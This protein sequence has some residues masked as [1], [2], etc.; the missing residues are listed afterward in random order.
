M[1][2]KNFTAS[3]ENCLMHC[4]RGDDDDVVVVV[5]LLFRIPGRRRMAWL[6]ALFLCFSLLLFAIMVCSQRN[7]F[8][9]GGKRCIEFYE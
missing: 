2:S 5:L 7:D 9:S 1:Q 8:F 4:L 6:V 3:E